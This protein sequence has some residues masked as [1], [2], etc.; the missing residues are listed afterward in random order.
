[1]KAGYSI[2]NFGTHQLSTSTT[3]TLRGA[4]NRLNELIKLG[5][6]IVITGVYVGASRRTPL[7]CSVCHGTVMI[8]DTA[9]DGIIIN[10]F[11][12]E[13]PNEESDETLFAE[14]DIYV[15]PD[16]T[17]VNQGVDY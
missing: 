17:I 7:I 1:M 4:Y 2:F 3:Q 9:K 11:L 5:K 14:R 13:T 6:P 10:G 16:D 15:F 8:D 12:D